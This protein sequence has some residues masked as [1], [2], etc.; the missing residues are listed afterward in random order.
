MSGVRRW[1]GSIRRSL[2]GRRPHVSSCT[3]DRYLVPNREQNMEL[4]APSR[5]KSKPNWKCSDAAPGAQAPR[6]LGQ[7]PDDFK[8]HNRNT[9]ARLKRV[10]PAHP[11]DHQALS[12][13]PTRHPANLFLADAQRC[14]SFDHARRRGMPTLMT[15]ICSMPRNRSGMLSGD[16][17]ANNCNNPC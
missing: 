1:S 15:R 3:T 10:D 7:I 12:A 13:E 16:L 4:W 5:S 8:S 11:T 9:F 2:G 6:N 14:Q 17:W